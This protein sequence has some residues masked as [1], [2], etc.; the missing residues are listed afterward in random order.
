[1][2]G[3]KITIFIVDDHQMLIDG[4]KALLKNDKKFDVIGSSTKSFECEETIVQANPDILLTDVQMPEVNGLELTKRIKQ[5]LP[6]L[7]VLVLTMF[8][9]K[10][11]ISDMISAGVSGY[12]LKN[13]GKEELK[14]ALLKIY[15]GGLFFSDEVAAEMMK[16]ITNNIVDDEKRAHLTERELEVVKLIAE[17]YN[18]AK[19]A[20][21]L[22][23]SE[24]T[25]E[26]HRKNIFRKTDTHTAL[27]LVKYAK[28]T[29]IL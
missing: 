2:I 18:N 7:K 12:I 22:F 9:D 17:D 1:M 6:H 4:I 28:E 15:S 29:G 27:G 20:E 26:T 10:S 16:S 14:E 5:K 19:I 3:E 21:L 8:C 24:R 25:V 13:T 23:I 11:M